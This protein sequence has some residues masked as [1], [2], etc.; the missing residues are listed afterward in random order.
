[1]VPNSARE[2]LAA[3]PEITRLRDAARRTN[4][5]FLALTP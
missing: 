5:A 1:V 2:I 3:G 4:D